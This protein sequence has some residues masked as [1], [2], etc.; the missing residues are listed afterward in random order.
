M[1][2]C[3]LSLSSYPFL[4]NINIGYNGG[5]EIEQVHLGNELV[6]KGIDVSFITY[7][8]GN[9][10]IEYKNGI[11]I[12]KTYN[13]EKRVNELS[14][15]NSI[16]KTL[17]E[18]DA[19]INF[20]EDR[21]YGILPIYCSLYKKKFVHRIASDAI[22]LGIKIFKYEDYLRKFLKNI[23][24]KNANIII[25]QNSLQKRILKNRN[26]LESI[27]IK[28]G[29]PINPSF[30]IEKC[31]NNKQTVLWVANLSIQKNP[32]IFIELAKSIP[33]ADFRMIGGE[34]PES[35]KLN[36]YVRE[37]SKKISNF[38]YYGYMPHYK[39]NNFIQNSSLLVNTSFFEG[40]PM[41]FLESWLACKPVVSLKVNPDKIITQK[42]LGYVSN[43]KEQ[44]RLD[45]IKLLENETLR[46]NMGKNGK[47]YV[48][49]EHDIRII[50]KK[51]IEVFNKLY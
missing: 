32:Q 16:I 34:S 5:A 30:K 22:V 21:S 11:K 8:Y 26:N 42:N 31:F 28:N 18:E 6:K 4:K 25:A 27:I 49:Q 36:E 29:I 12:I 43:N 45:V 44:L 40:F 2:I 33:N 35:I 7:F 13:P 38:T 23:E 37:S 39:V 41:T 47:N 51:Y 9:K 24:L 15:L 48:I 20:H 46:K 50:I 17:K 14:K 10:R 1:K 19:D 3:F